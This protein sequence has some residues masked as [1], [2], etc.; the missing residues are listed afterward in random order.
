MSHELGQ[1]I[2]FATRLYLRRARVAYVGYVRRDPLVL[3]GLGP[4]RANPYPFYEQ[5]R[6]GGGFAPTSPGGGF[7]PT[8]KYEWVSTSYSHCNSI[9]RDRRF[10]VVPEGY[11][12][13]GRGDGTDLSFLNMNPPDHG[14]LRRLAT[15]AFS[16]TAAAKYQ[17]WIEKATGELLDSA[18]SEGR[19][20]L[21]NALAARLPIAA[22]CYLLG[23]P[24]ADVAAIRR[25]GQVVGSALDGIKSPRH[26]A[27]LQAASVEMRFLFENLFELRRREPGDDLISQL[28]A[29]EGDQLTPAEL[30][31]MC[32]LLLLAGFETTASLIGT[33]VLAL[34]DN[35]EQWKAL[36]AD[37]AAMAGKAA[38]EALRYESPIQ[39]V[40]RF[41]LEPVEVAGH[42]VAKGEQVVVLIGA[43]NH[44]P[45][46][47]ERPDAFDIT[48]PD[49]LP[50]LA[51]SSGIHYCLGQP[52]AVLEGTIALRM[53]A[54][55][56][57][58]LA[59]AGAAK[60]RNG[61]SL[62]GLLSLPVTVGG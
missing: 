38:E 55:R 50:H 32:V 26:A 3:L 18:A 8:R 39:V 12:I 16:R 35:P 22:M 5:L 28:V 34:L 47:Y 54:E 57:P 44:D 61:T 45:E 40:Q 41:A 19:F 2:T 46:V 24:D 7:A 33:G 56:M 43:A 10:G 37:P 59:R 51:F 27:Q 23:I 60:R 21:I 4:G 36:V 25:C 48:R 11:K 58:G 30:L 13:G 17:S 14:R 15:P 49:P 42:E 62:R 29:V 6:A 9:V 52:L 20:D 31:S 53:L 1:T